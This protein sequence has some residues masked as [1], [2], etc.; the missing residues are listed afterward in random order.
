MGSRVSPAESCAQ[1]QRAP[2]RMRTV[3][4]ARHAWS[5]RQKRLVGPNY[6]PEVEEGIE[7]YFARLVTAIDDSGVARAPRSSGTL[8][9]NLWKGLGSTPNEKWSTW[10]ARVRVATSLA[11]SW[12]GPA[13][14][15]RAPRRWKCTTDPAMK[16][17]PYGS[18]SALVSPKCA[19]HSAESGER[20]A[21]DECVPWCH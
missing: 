2:R 14:W 12:S 11:L 21:A 8:S 4:P 10:S 1:A 18:D 16:I 19:C 17:A 7:D 3:C 15:G 20:T 6:P 5:V 13:S 9:A